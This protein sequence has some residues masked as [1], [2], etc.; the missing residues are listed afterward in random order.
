MVKLNEE[1]CDV[2][3]DNKSLQKCIT[4]VNSVIQELERKYSVFEDII[5]CRK[6][7]ELNRDKNNVKQ[8]HAIELQN[9]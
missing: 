1:K 4:A 5:N 6:N 7:D 8:D 9:I 3:K 2:E